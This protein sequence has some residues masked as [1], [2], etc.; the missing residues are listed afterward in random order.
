MKICIVSDS[1]DNRK[2]L[3]VAVRDA[4]NCGADGLKQI[5]LDIF[6]R[7]IVSYPMF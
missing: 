1:Y 6:L 5:D 2:L 7:R 3:D 4:R